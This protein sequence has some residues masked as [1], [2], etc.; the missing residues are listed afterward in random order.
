[1]LVAAAAA[2]T[3]EILVETVGLA[4]VVASLNP[5]LQVLAVW[6]E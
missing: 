6:L 4:E 5:T 1:V 3:V 2:I